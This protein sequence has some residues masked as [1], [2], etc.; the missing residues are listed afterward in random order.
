MGEL[1]KVIN[2]I[3]VV[4]P[5]DAKAMEAARKDPSDPVTRVQRLGSLLAASGY[6]KDAEDVAK[7]AVKIM[8]GEEL[9]IPPV[10][11][12]MGINVIKGKTS[13]SANLM[14]ASLRRH[15][16]DYRI[17]RLDNQGCLIKFLG[18][19]ENGK[20]E[21]LGVSEFTEADAKA[22]LLV[23]KEGDMYKKFPRNMFFG[24]A[25]SNGVKWYTPEVTSGIPIYTPEEL[26]AQVDADGELVGAIHE[27]PPRMSGEEFAAYKAQRVAEAEADLQQRQAQRQRPQH[28]PAEPV[29]LD[30]FQQRLASLQ[31]SIKSIEDYLKVMATLKARIEDLTGSDAPYYDI[32]REF[33]FEHAN[34]LKSKSQ[35]AAVVREVATKVYE[36]EKQIFAEEATA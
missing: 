14:A 3:E 28:S 26:G 10:A 31:G 33:G 9:G 1:A 15:G 19:L 24:R 30:E 35:W 36:I 22:A 6:F 34:Q 23:G 8:A 17:V 7:A 13:L 11:A 32:L 29:V 5:E 4:T 20:R 21:E 16:Y 25:M 18:K 27:E 12:M 2:G